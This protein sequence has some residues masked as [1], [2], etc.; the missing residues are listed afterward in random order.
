MNAKINKLFQAAGKQ[1][2]M[3]FAVLTMAMV[4]LLVIPLPPWLLD[5]LLAV[6]MVMGVGMLMYA[7]Y[8]HSP[9]MLSA[10][11]S[12]LLLST[13][14][15]IAL[16]VA[17]TR[18]ILLAGDAGHIIEAFGRFVVGGNL[19]VGLVVFIIIALVQLIVVSKGAE[20]VAEVSA[21]FALDGLPGRQMSIDA[22]VRAG[23]M[24]SVQ[25][26]Y[27]RRMLLAESAMFG[28]MDGAMKFV[29]GDVI[30]GMIIVVINL[31]GGIA[32]GVIYAGMSAG[33][34]VDHYSVLAIGDGLVSQIPGLFAA[35]AAG[36]LVTRS[37]NSTA[38]NLGWEILQQLRMQPKALL[39]TGAIATAVGLVPGLPTLVFIC[40][41][42]PLLAMGAWLHKTELSG[43]GGWAGLTTDN[44]LREG[45]PSKRA[46]LIDEQS[47]EFCTVC[48]D[49]H[50]DLVLDLSP[51][52][53]DAALTRLRGELKIS[54]G[55]PYP[56]LLVRQTGK[57]EPSQYQITVLGN[58]CA[59]AAA[60]KGSCYFEG[61]VAALTELGL[62]PTGNGLDSKAGC[63]L[64]AEDAAA[65]RAVE[66]TLLE[67]EDGLIRVVGD[68]MHKQ[69]HV[70]F[71][72]Q[73]MQL[74]LGQHEGIYPD[75]CREAV[76]LVPLT[77]MTKI[78]KGLL[79]EGVSIRD[80][81]TILD[82]LVY[83][84]QEPGDDFSL[85][86]LVRKALTLQICKTLVT[87]N[88]VLQAVML[89][90]LL[91]GQFRESLQQTPLGPALQLPPS[92]AQQFQQGV[93]QAIERVAAKGST[94]H[95]SV[96]TAPDLRLHVRRLLEPSLPQI[97]VLATDEIAPGVRLQSLGMLRG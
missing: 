30:A 53:I 76:N 42:L 5:I 62:K 68:V 36:V 87:P 43:K 27:A 24:T 86:E 40:I 92:A 78:L 90:P 14:F 46:L 37:S 25:A 38:P 1:A 55:L 44:A 23:S 45:Q 71:G 48:L 73:E 93:T 70:L 84:A 13:M 58:V 21:R 6:S 83:G 69:A 79:R 60:P 26:Q 95:I 9:V 65:A 19:V 75:L 74:V 85:G 35:L 49:I 57:L 50:D 41:G 20:R 15:R 18:Q 81:R 54:L 94:A 31:L 80:M 10:F 29:K 96:V 63:W 12:V 34:A 16:N 77:R 72:I 89:D 47:A 33:A 11:P 4:A 91:E 52:V 2:D 3:A 56:G 88:N 8:A 64:S 66:R 61:S 28:S 22:D 59:K 82:A 32:V 39:V 97:A 7:L 51:E 67:R 17:T